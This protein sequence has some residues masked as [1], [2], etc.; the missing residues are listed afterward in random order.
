[1]LC[2]PQYSWRMDVRGWPET[3]PERSGLPTD[4]VRVV[5]VEASAA[6]SPELCA[7]ERKY[8]VAVTVDKPRHEACAENVLG[9]KGALGWL[10]LC[11]SIQKRR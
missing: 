7:L 1:M 6:C 2:N 4:A 9:E 10:H 8:M 3:S 5:V 11:Y